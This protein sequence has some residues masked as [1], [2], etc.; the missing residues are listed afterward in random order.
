MNDFDYAIACF[1]RLSW[2]LS[3]GFVNSRIKL[4]PDLANLL[5]TVSLRE[6]P[7]LLRNQIQ[8]SAR[9][10]SVGVC[11][12]Q[13]VKHRQEAREDFCDCQLVRK[14]P[15][16]LHSLSIVR[17]LGL[18]PLQ[19]IE[20]LAIARINFRLLAQIKQLLDVLIGQSLALD[21]GLRLRLRLG[22]RL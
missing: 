15:I 18:N 16:P 9:Q 5:K 4:I 12:I 10:I 2:N 13:I 3:Y 20:V 6:D 21:Y 11:K 22:R 7:N 17:V 14:Q 19:I 8:R 1:L